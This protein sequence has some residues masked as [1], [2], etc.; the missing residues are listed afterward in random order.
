MADLVTVRKLANGGVSYTLPGK[1]LPRHWKGENAKQKVSYEELEECMM[2]PAIRTLFSKGYLFIEDIMVRQ[3]LDLEANE[4]FTPE[5]VLD[6]E[7]ILPIL[8][9]DDFETFKTKVKNMSE[10][11]QQLLIDVA[12]TNQKHAGYEK[13]DF[14]R[15]TFKIDIESVQRRNR[16]DLK[17]G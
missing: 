2:D 15:E 10:Q 16:E 1:T 17:G 8:Y 6:K 3:L 7:G 9:E 11:T 14:I 13:Y 5:L 12:T 4:Y